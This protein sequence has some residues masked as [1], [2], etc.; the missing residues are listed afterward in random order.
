MIKFT[1]DFNGDEL[2]IIKGLNNPGRIQDFLNQIPFNFE[3]QGDICLSPRRVLREKRAHC[4]EGALLAAAALWRHGD[5][6]LIFDLRSTK[7]DL[8]HVVALFRRRGHWG[9]ISKTNHGVLRFREPVYRTLRELALSYFHEYFLDDGVKTLR[10]YSAKPFDLRQRSLRGWTTDE[11]DLDYLVDALDDAP[12]LS[13]LNRAM[14]RA[15]RRAD[16]VE[17]AAG[18]VVEWRDKVKRKK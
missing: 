15:L 13:I 6:P 4:V 16:A 12:H 9:A 11:K 2:G 3:K 1:L 14:L 5:P 7:R 8:D 17:I 10:D 18:K